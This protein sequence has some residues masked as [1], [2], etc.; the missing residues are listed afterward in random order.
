MRRS[1]VSMTAFQLG[2]S[3]HLLLH[4]EAHALR[5]INFVLLHAS[6]KSQSWSAQGHEGDGEQ[7]VG[8]RRH[9]AAAVPPRLPSSV[10]LGSALAD[11]AG[12]LRGVCGACHVISQMP[13]N[14]LCR[15]PSFWPAVGVR[16]ASAQIFAQVL[17]T[18]LLSTYFEM[19]YLSAYA[20]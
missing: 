20:E 7:R 18:S 12:R 3:W 5:I 17:Y 16:Y 4:V 15:F 11:P 10:G 1:S 13:G 8:A 9:Q 2:L 6:G 19:T 14:L